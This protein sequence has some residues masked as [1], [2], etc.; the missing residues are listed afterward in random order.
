MILAQEEMS[1]ITA[2]VFICISKLSGPCQNIG[3]GVDISRNGGRG[4][5]GI[6]GYNEGGKG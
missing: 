1:W 4:T 5:S 3:P 2:G 6:Q